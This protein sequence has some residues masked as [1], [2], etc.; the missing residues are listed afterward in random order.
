MSGYGSEGGY[1][2]LDAYRIVKFVSQSEI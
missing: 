1:E 2:G